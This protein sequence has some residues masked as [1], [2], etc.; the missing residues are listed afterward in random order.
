MLS[1][2]A[3][4]TVLSSR[5]GLR[6]F[7]AASRSIE[8]DFSRLFEVLSPVHEE[9]HVV[10]KI[11]STSDIDLLRREIIALRAE[12]KAD[13]SII[14]QELG[15][16]KDQVSDYKVF[17][18]RRLT[19]IEMGVDTALSKLKNSIE[20]QEVELHSIAHQLEKTRE[21]IRKVQKDNSTF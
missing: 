18:A 4:N 12:R 15:R 19:D 1:I 17:V 5:V 13:R 20:S 21:L 9:D 16:V 14:E 6:A 2:A 3:K 7:S 10:H 8:S 11:H